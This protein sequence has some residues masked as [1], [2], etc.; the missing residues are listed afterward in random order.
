MAETPHT[1]VVVEYKTKMPWFLMLNE[2]ITAISY[3]VCFFSAIAVIWMNVLG[4]KPPVSSLVAFIL[5][6]LVFFVFSPRL[7]K[8]DFNQLLKDAKS[9]EP[10]NDTKED[11]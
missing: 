1:T 3:V 9:H 4:Y 10:A 8:P 11:I 5:M 6:S 7:P 2:I